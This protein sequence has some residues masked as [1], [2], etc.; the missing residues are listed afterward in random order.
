MF[1]ILKRPQKRLVEVTLEVSKDGVSWVDF[2]AVVGPETSMLDFPYAR[3][4]EVYVTE[5]KS[6][7]SVLETREGRV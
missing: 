4:M 3:K 6:P 2:D 5:M 1:G 7:P